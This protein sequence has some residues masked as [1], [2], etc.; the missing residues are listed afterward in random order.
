MS[1]NSVNFRGP[2]PDDYAQIYANQN[3]LSLEDAKAELKSKYGDPTQDGSNAP[4][5]FNSLST[6]AD[7]FIKVGDIGMDPDVFAQQYADENGITLDEAKAKLEELYGK[8]EEMSR[9]DDMEFDQDIDPDYYV[10]LYAAENN[11]TYEEAKAYF[12]EHYGAFN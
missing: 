3:N 8:P 7:E 5:I 11:I 6:S 9:A 10:K 1:V 12:E 4:S 2:N